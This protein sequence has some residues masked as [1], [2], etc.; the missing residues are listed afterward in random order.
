MDEAL[1]KIAR[2]L[3]ESLHAVALTGA[4]VSTESGLPDFRSRGG[5]WQDQDA[6]RLLS[7]EVLYGD[8]LRFYSR[9]LH[10]LRTFRGRSPNAAHRALARLE[11]MGLLKCVITQNIDGL[12]QAAGSQNVLEIHG[13][14][15]TASCLVCRRVFP[16]D[17]LEETVSAGRIPPEC[18]ACGGTMRP[19]VVFFG[20]PMAPDFERAVEECS[21]SD[22][23]LVVGSSLQVAP[24]AY[25]PGL[26]PRIAIVNLEPTAY[27]DAAEAV[28]HGKAGTVLTEL[29]RV[30]EELA[31][32]PETTTER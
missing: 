12:H 31:G 10:L 19:D 25:L 4:G 29:V 22:F 21:R 27:D 17:F 28:I 32:R 9:G 8:P 24:A 20:D 14:L 26:V 18:P 11:E 6:V 2:M 23:M 30:V 16:F 7:L 5:L 1:R 13:H 15:R 3:V